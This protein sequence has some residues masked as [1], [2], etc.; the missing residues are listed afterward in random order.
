MF[1]HTKGYS[2]GY[3]RDG[4]QWARGAFLVLMSGDVRARDGKPAL[5]AFVRH[6]VLKQSGHFMTGLIRCSV[7]G[8]PALLSVEGAYGNNGLPHDTGFRNHIH[9]HVPY[10]QREVIDLW[11]LSHDVP[12]DISSAY[13]SGDGHNSAGCEAPVLHTWALSNIYALRKWLR[14][15]VEQEQYSQGADFLLEEAY[16]LENQLP[17]AQVQKRIEALR[18]CADYLNR[19]GS[20]H[21]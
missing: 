3:L 9:K 21:E 19:R 4:T 1:L 11:S 7:R 5:R 6:V 10:E 17:D 12:A 15:G 8:K 13:W 20:A 18:A 14:R 2:A 16:E